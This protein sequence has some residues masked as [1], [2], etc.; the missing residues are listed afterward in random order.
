MCRALTLFGGLANGS[1]DGGING[2]QRAAAD[3]R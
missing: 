3:Y 1:K 2:Q